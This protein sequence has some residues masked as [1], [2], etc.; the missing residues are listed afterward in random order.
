[1][2]MQ[3][4]LIKDTDAE[5]IPQKKPFYP[6]LEAELDEAIRSLRQ[7]GVCLNGELIIAQARL[8]ATDMHLQN[9]K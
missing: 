5:L 7:I 6:A 9:F 1:M 2:L 3:L 4:W 8:I